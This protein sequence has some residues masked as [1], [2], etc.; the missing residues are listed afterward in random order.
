MK[1]NIPAREPGETLVQVSR[2]DRHSVV[3]NEEWRATTTVKRQKG[4]P[5]LQKAFDF[6]DPS[7]ELFRWILEVCHLL[8]I[9]LLIKRTMSVDGP[10]VGSSFINCEGEVEIIKVYE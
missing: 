5:E 6:I 7:W 8:L 10:T 4:I 1:H 3:Q 2:A 9:Y